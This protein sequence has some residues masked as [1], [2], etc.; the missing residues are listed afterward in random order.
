MAVNTATNITRCFPL[1]GNYQLKFG[2]YVMCR[3][4]AFFLD[5]KEIA[6]AFSLLWVSCPYKKT[7]SV[8]EC[9]NTT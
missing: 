4:S 9:K 1:F 7:H 6:H 3:I 5:I 8:C 2:I